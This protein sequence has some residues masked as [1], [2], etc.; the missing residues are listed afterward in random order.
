MRHIRSAVIVAAAGVAV[1]FA[2]VFFAVPFMNDSTLLAEAK[3]N[4]A[5]SLVDP[6]S[7]RF[8]DLRIVIDG[9]GHRNVCGMVNA[10]DKFGGYAGLA[11]FVYFSAAKQ[12]AIE[13]TGMSVEEIVTGG[14]IT[15]LLIMG[16]CP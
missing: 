5:L 15:D 7:A 12:S 2:V 11:P 9:R 8:S 14:K 16:G 6:E 1:A 3:K 4:V 10:K 13:A